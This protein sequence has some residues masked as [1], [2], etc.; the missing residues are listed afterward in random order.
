MGLRL[1]VRELLR[2]CGHALV[3]T[4]HERLDVLERQNIELR[5]QV[6]SITET[7]GA[8]LQASIHLVESLHRVQ[9]SGFHL[10]RGIS[11]AYDTLLE[12]LRSTVSRMTELQQSVQETVRIARRDIGALGSLGSICIE[13]QNYEFLNPEVGLMA[14][15]YS[16][17][18]AGNAVDVGAH[19]G[20]V[21]NHL[22]EAGYEVFAF[23]PH[24][25]VFG[26]LVKRLADRPRF[27]PFNCAL[28]SE[29]GE[30]SLN[31]A[32]DT[33]ETKRHTDE[34]LYSS[35]V[36][37]S[38]PDDLPFTETQAV[39]V[40]TLADLHRE[41][42]VPAGVSL[43]KIDTEGFDLNVIRGMEDY[44]YPVVVTEY[45]DQDIP[46]ARAGVPYTLRSLIGEMRFRGY[47]YHIVIYRTWGSDQMAYYCNLGQS[48]PKSYG[49]SFFFR[50]YSLFDR[51]QRWCSTVLPRT[52]FR[53]A[54]SC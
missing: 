37:H 25:A 5:H 6:T 30:M 54:S 49:N 34:T 20:E 13:T 44:R 45:W 17:L 39:R 46:F 41:G 50:D 36:S 22:L 38:M 3:R 32:K 11:D 21:S 9:R 15:L 23:E 31:L 33:S 42:V 18:P 10:D 28:G 26:S 4:V 27:H 35:L 53:P 52:Y 14:F 1:Q 19:V 47:P 51:A 48:V 24:P 40:R 16:S 12:D 2:M 43:V 29:D 7:Q 8:L